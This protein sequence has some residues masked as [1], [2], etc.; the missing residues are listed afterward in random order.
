M[1]RNPQHRF[2]PAFWAAL[3]FLALSPPTAN[4]LNFARG[5]ELYNQQCQSCHEDLMHARN[6]KLKTLDALRG[7]IQDWA[8]HTGNPWTREDVNDVLYYLNKSFYGFDQ[9]PL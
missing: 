6:R 4:A 9:K 2:K 3:I 8:S 7:R 5:Q 1:T